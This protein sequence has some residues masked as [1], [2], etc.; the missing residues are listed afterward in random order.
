MSVHLN[1][2]IVNLSPVKANRSVTDPIRQ[3]GG[4]PCIAFPLE[5]CYWAVMKPPIEID[6]GGF[7]SGVCWDRGL[8]GSSWW[9]CSLFALALAYVSAWTGVAAMTARSAASR[10]IARTSILGR[11]L[12]EDGAY[13]DAQG[14]GVVVLGPDA[15]AHR[16]APA[17]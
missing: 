17:P 11:G 4:A 6:G 15:G 1:N 2:T 5:Y 10:N 13:G 9:A 14:A 7:G 12:A 16:A 8:S 3:L